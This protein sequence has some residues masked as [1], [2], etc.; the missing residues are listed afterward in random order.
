MPTNQNSSFENSQF[1]QSNMSG[2]MSTM[3][4]STFSPVPNTNT[5]Q[6]VAAMPTAATHTTVAKKT[7]LQATASELAEWVTTIDGMTEKGRSKTTKFIK[8]E[9]ISGFVLG[10]LR[11]NLEAIK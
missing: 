9:N 3:P 2:T 11:G 7:L 1:D 4:Y 6:P 8:N 10:E 5:H